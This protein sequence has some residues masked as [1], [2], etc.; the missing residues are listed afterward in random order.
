MAIQSYPLHV[1]NST[2]MAFYVS[3][4]FL[5]YMQKNKWVS[6]LWKPKR[7]LQ[8]SSKRLSWD[9]NAASRYSLS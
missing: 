8:T 7:F 5:I 4:L 1:H 3:Y 2:L 6:L 9:K